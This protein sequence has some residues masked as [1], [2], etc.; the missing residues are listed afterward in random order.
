MEYLEEDKLALLLHKE[1]LVKSDS[2]KS[3]S[4]LMKFH[5]STV[6][7]C[8]CLMIT[9]T[10]Q[11]WGEVITS[12]R[13]ARR[14][15]ECNPGVASLLLL[16]E[17]EEDE[18]RSQALDL[19]SAAHSL[20]G[21]VDL[22]FET[23][24]SRNADLAFELRCSEFKW[25]WETYSLG[26]KVSAEVISKHL[27]MPLISLTHMAF[28]SSEAVSA[29]TEADLE[30]SV[31]KVGRTAR[32]TV[33][34][35]IRTAISKPRVTTSLRRMTAVF[36]FLP[37][38]PAVISEAQTPELKL[39]V[40]TSK[41]RTVGEPESTR[42]GSVRATTRSPSPGPSRKPASAANKLA[43]ADDSSATEQST[44]NEAPQAATKGKG[45]TADRWSRPNSVVH[46]RRNSPAAA[47]NEASE[48]L[49]ARP[50]KKSKRVSSDSDSDEDTPEA[51]KRRLA[52]L[53]GG[54]S[55]RGVKQPVKRGGKRF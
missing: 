25:R 1:W 12:S 27:I 20:G 50:I 43:P 36:N 53:K 29:Q 9:D 34:T 17:E 51:R 55:A 54:S 41:T 46:S 6:D 13:I 10:K 30:K 14:W 19:L 3:T 44:D 42:G 35:H 24:E 45:K 8:C 18:W 48:S 23:V 15:R 22:S 33:D 49:P 21:I 37:D 11:V 4:Y 7:Q 26:P 31:D 40:I 5:A 39:P 2:S 38:M 52:R 47:S 32:R 16:S 28:S